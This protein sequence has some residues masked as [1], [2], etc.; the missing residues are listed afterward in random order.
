M[1]EECIGCEWYG[2]PYWSIINPC[3]HCTKRYKN[4]TIKVKNYSIKIDNKELYDKIEQLK[5]QLQEEKKIKEDAIEYVKSNAF[6]Q[7]TREYGMLT[8][9][10]ADELLSILERK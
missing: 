3:S 6:E 4:K 7:H 8:L 1:S 10:D 9:V 5:S 2:K